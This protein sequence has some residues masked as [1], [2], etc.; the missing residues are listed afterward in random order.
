MKGFVSGRYRAIFKFWASMVME[1]I[2]VVCLATIIVV[3]LIVNT[4]AMV[5]LIY[6]SLRTMK[7]KV[8]FMLCVVNSLQSVGFGMELTAA[9]RGGYACFLILIKI[10]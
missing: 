5:F 8:V 2:S 10:F 9:I 1:V 7:N 4:L 6:D 3:G